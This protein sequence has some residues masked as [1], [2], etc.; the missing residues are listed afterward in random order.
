M[1][2]DYFQSR[3]APTRQEEKRKKAQETR[4]HF[5]IHIYKYIYRRLCHKL[6]FKWPLFYGLK[7]RK[8]RKS[9]RKSWTIIQNYE[10]YKRK[11][12]VEYQ[13]KMSSRDS[14][15]ASPVCRLYSITPQTLVPI[16]TRPNRAIYLF[17]LHCLF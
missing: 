16:L 12:R 8:G 15:D 17:S 4:F 11:K 5:H 10:L 3:Q 13:I 14:G 6:D 1:R 9:Y 2:L 7:A